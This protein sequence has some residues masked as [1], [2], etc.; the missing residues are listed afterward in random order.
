M[1]EESSGGAVHTAAALFKF[2]LFSLSVF[3]IE[4]KVSEELANYIF[5]VMDEF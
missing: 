4:R 5:K 1:L 3:F 2:F